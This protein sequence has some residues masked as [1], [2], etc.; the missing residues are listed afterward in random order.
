MKEILERLDLGETN[1]GTW[2][3]AEAFE[4]DDAPLIESINPAN[5]EVIASVR[6]TTADEYDRLVKNA[7]V[8]YRVFHRPKAPRRRKKGRG[9]VDNA[10]ALTTSPQP[11][12]HQ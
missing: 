12:Q 2:S 8:A 3:G 4:S 6:S 11:Q 7:R 10:D 1:A 9:F 5:G